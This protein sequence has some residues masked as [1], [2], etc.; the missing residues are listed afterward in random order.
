MSQGTPV[1][2]C[3]K[4][5]KCTNECKNRVTQK[6]QKHY[7]SIFKTSN[8]RGWGVRTNKTIARGRFIAKFVGEIITHEE[9][10]RRSEIYTFENRKYFF[11]LDLE[12]KDNPYTIDAAKIGNFTRFINHSCDP[13]VG[14]W[15]IHTATDC[16]LPTLCFFSLR[17]IE[18]GEELT[19]DYDPSGKLC[20][21]DE[22]NGVKKF[23]KSEQIKCLC[24]A[25][26]CR[27]VIF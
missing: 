12:Q 16:N 6:G 8:G 10:E 23:S 3:N 5:C 9:C 11:D 7:L 25:P 14:V 21:A 15:V 1:Y 4:H 13:N 19:L 20:D 27:K 17:R 18:A 22:M 26:N 2:E 24:G